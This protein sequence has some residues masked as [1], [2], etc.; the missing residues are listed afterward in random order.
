MSDT[1]LRPVIENPQ[2]DVVLVGTITVGDRAQHNVAE[3]VVGHWQ[4]APWPPE[5]LSLTVYTS[6]DEASVL[7]YAQWSSQ[8]ALERSLKETDGVSDTARV[9]GTPAA[10]PVPYRLYRAVRGSAVGDPAPV[11][12]SFPVAFFDAKDHQAARD[13]VDGLFA[14]EEAGE[15][16]ERAYPG[17]ISA[18]MHI[19]LDGTRI[20]S[21]SEWVTEAQ[22]V[23][24]IEAVWEPLLKELGGT[25]LLYRHHRSLFPS[26]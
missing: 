22:A 17:G 21:F 4:S 12:G 7:T 14:A 20:L 16:D 19:S 6:S 13:F 15:G 11:A 18:N 3:A 26:A 5:L 2:S 9:V 23:A 24:H 25:G 1:S 8:E 10:A